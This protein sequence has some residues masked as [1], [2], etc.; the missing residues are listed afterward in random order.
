[1]IA[2]HLAAKRVLLSICTIRC[3][4]GKRGPSLGTRSKPS[5]IHAPHTQTYTQS[6]ATTARH[7]EPALLR[8]ANNCDAH[9]VLT[10]LGT[11]RAEDAASTVARLNRVS[12][13]GHGVLASA[14]GSQRTAHELFPVLRALLL[15]GADP[16]H[17]GL[18]GGTPLG[19]AC[20]HADAPTRRALV[21]L[22]LAH[23][24]DPTLEC[25]PRTGAAGDAGATTPL[26]FAVR[27]DD[28]YH[29]CASLLVVGVPPAPAL[30]EAWQAA[31]AS[32]AMG[33]TRQL[34]QRL[35]DANSCAMAEQTPL[36]AGSGAAETVAVAGGTPRV[37]SVGELLA[38]NWSPENH[39][40]WPP[41]FHAAARTL[42]LCAYRDVSGH[43]L[44]QILPM[45]PLYHILWHLACSWPLDGNRGRWERRDGRWQQTANK[46]HVVAKAS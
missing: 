20:R 4:K 24:A 42:L 19:C 14:I 17:R 44:L 29:V 18:A 3:T 34:L 45:E 39:A 10:W 27:S 16:N 21:R 41:K 11:Q 33:P 9:G 5:H 26:A 46:M 6:M 40:L 12:R 22:L 1:M 28:A 7:L 23:G 13:R 36:L 37:G 43:H 15:A 35:R 8:A 25:G 38:C 32:K 31:G 2:S 30:L